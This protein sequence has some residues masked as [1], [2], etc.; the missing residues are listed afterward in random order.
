MMAPDELKTLGEDIK[1][2]GLTTPVTVWMDDPEADPDSI[3]LEDT[4]PLEALEP[5]AFTPDTP[6][7]E[8]AA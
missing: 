6:D 8:A 7:D 3:L 1:R 5:D 4:L 2:N